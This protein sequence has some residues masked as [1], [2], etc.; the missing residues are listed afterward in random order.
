MEPLVKEHSLNLEKNLIT[1]N[2]VTN[3][4]NFDAKIIVINL[5]TNSLTIRGENLN[6][7]DLD[8]KNQTL[9]IQGKVIN[10]Q[11]GRK[12]EKTSFL[13]KLFK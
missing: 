3:V 4:E 9:L 11:Y 10:I 2:G 8:I 7:I 5:N 6:I 12:L 1:I 13:K